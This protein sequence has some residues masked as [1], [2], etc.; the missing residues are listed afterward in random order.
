MCSCRKTSKRLILFCGD[1]QSK[2]K[3]LIQ[4][5]GLSRCGNPFFLSR[6]QQ[7]LRLA[8]SGLKFTQCP[9]VGSQ[10]RR[11][12][13]PGNHALLLTNTILGIVDSI[14]SPKILHLE[15]AKD[16]DTWTKPDFLLRSGLPPAV[17]RDLWKIYEQLCFE[18]RAEGQTMTPPWYVRSLALDTMGEHIRKAIAEAVDT[19]KTD[20]MVVLDQLV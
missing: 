5:S 9:L 14:S 10:S 4:T 7:I 18:K 1:S 8:N 16:T 3:E 17:I 19:I 20:H 15:I 12:K 2:T 11:P 6:F 13:H